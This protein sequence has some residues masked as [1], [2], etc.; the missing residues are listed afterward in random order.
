MRAPSARPNGPPRLTRGRASL[1]QTA[2]VAVAGQP[3]G[4]A[5]ARVV[6][7]QQRDQL[8]LEHLAEPRAGT[9]RARRRRRAA[10]RTIRSTM[11]ARSR[12]S[13]RTPCCVG[14]LGGAVS[15]AVQDRATR[16]PAAAATASRA[17]RRPPGRRAAAR[18]PR[19]RRPGRAAA[20][21]VGRVEQSPGRPG[22][23]RSRRP[24]RPPR[25]PPTAPHPAVSMTVTSGSPSSAASRM[26]AARLAQA[27]RDRAARRRPGGAG[28]GRGPRTARRRTAPARAA[29]RARSRP[30]PV[31]WSGYDVGA[32]YR[33][34]RRTPGRSGRRERVIDSHA[35]TSSERLE[36]HGSA[37]SGSAARAARPARRARGRRRR[38]APPAATTASRR[39]C[40]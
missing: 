13:E 39:P 10:R 19:R 6:A 5:G 32:A 27:G 36:R 12:S 35:G 7:P 21:S 30:A 15:R 25:P 8:V 34:S 31:P 28:P 1:G 4:E 23:G 33:S 3:G 37:T 2:E 11:P 22:S 14:H 18:A 9:P 29:A 20:H 17:A 24:D 38:R 26:P 40:S 16:P